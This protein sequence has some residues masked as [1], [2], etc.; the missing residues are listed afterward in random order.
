MG[1][2]KITCVDEGSGK[3]MVAIGYRS[4]WY[5]YRNVDAVSLC[6]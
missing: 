2:N 6:N 1:E 4:D 5:A 3:K